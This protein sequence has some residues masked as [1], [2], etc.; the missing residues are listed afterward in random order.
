MEKY[1]VRD[2][3]LITW[4]SGPVERIKQWLEIAQ[5]NKN[6]HVIKMDDDNSGKKISLQEI[7]KLLKASSN[8]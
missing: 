5:K 3:S 6:F 2:Y 4:A 1:K 8:G 7:N